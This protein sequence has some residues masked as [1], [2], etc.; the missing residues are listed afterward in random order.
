MKKL[1]PLLLLYGCEQ[2]PSADETIAAHTLQFTDLV[3]YENLT[4]RAS[5]EGPD[6]SY[7]TITESDLSSGY[8]LFK[9][10]YAYKPNPFYALIY[11]KTEGYGL[12]SSLTNQGALS[13]NITAVLKAHEFHELMFQVDQR[14][15]E[16]EAGN[17]TVYFD[18][19]CRQISAVD[20][21]D[22]PVKLFFNKETALMEGL[23]QANPYKKGEVIRVHFEQW[24]KKG[25]LPI[26]TKVLIHQGKNQQ[27][28]FNYQDI[29]FDEPG[30][31]KLR[32][33]GSSNGS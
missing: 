24:V 4:T 31:E 10:T 17:D 20:H 6:G 13:N 29:A 12:D 30:F 2:K 28:E 7:T 23:S 14:Y 9:Q 32:V 26:F 21:L 1:I 3:K 25:T 15:F 11:S 16:M 33:K 8:L 18:V 27:Y 22:Y 5:C 19:K